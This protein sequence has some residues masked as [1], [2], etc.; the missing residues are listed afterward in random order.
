MKAG[1]TTITAGRRTGPDHQGYLMDVQFYPDLDALLAI[2][3]HTL[4]RVRYACQ[5]H[6]AVGRRNESGSLIVRG[7]H[8]ILT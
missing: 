6:R 2:Y 8:I 5:G 1:Y 7:H 3:R 4:Q